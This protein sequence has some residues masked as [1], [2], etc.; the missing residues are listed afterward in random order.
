MKPYITTTKN[1]CW[2]DSLACLLEIDP[3]F[4]PDFVNRYGDRYMDKT[5]EWLKKE[6][7]KGL[8][9]I[10]AAA[11]M[12]TGDVRQNASIGPDGYSIAYMEM[13]DDAFAHA[14]VCFNGGVFWDNGDERHEEYRYI[15]GF[16]IIYDLEGAG[17]EKRVR[18]KKKRVKPGL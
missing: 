4:V 17:V 13:V 18:K 12:E 10:S 3:K 16:Y 2:R 7:G 6:Y 9:Y 11:F 1:T 5:R 8:V 15:K 14:L